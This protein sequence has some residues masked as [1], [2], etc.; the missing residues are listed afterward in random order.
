MPNPEV[1]DPAR[2]RCARKNFSGA[3]RMSVK[4]RWPA[5]TSRRSSVAELNQEGAYGCL[6]MQEIL[7]VTGRLLRHQ[8][9]FCCRRLA[10]AAN[11]EIEVFALEI[12]VRNGRT[13]W[14]TSCALGVFRSVIRRVHIRK[15]ALYSVA[16]VNPFTFMERGSVNSSG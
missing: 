8:D 4:R 1:P 14:R 10:G 2:S 16:R 7:V 13:G 15:G 5:W 3:S 12:D 6:L 9:G 11:V